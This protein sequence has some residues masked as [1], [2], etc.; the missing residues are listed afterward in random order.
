MSQTSYRALKNTFI[1]MTIFVGGCATTQSTDNYLVYVDE[2]SVIL[3]GHDPVAYFTE[4]RAVQGSSKH[5]SK[6]HGA[7][8]HFTSAANKKLFDSDPEQYKPQFGG[9]CSM[10]M[11]MG[12]LEPGD[13]ATGSI[14]DG[15]LVVQRNEKAKVM[16]SKDPRGNLRKADHNWP[17]LVNEHGKQG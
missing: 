2:T 15:R 16:W 14:V 4:G 5:K 3:Q 10:A 1:A 9:H 7:V 11:S 12:K 13:P 8:Y 17:R 6:Y